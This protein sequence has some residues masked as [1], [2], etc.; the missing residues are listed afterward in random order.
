MKAA[1]LHYAIL[2]RYRVYEGKWNYSHISVAKSIIHAKK[3]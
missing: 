3:I 2:E 1:K